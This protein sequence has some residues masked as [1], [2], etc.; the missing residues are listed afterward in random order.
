VAA[1]FCIALAPLGCGAAAHDATL[2]PQAL[3][4]PPREQTIAESTI[5]QLETCA[6]EA[7]GRF[8]KYSHAA[9]FDI[10]VTSSGHVTRVKLRTSTLEDSVLESCLMRAIGAMTVPVEALTLRSSEPYSGGEWMKRSGEPLGIA[11]ALGG[12]IALGP[13]II[14]AGGATIG[15][16]IGAVV[17]D[18]ATTATMDAL[19]EHREKLRCRKVLEKCIA[20]CS[21]ETLP[22]GELGGDSFHKCRKE[23]LDAENCWGV[24]LH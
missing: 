4:S 10:E 7:S 13:I 2:V 14:V 19:D 11:Q 21:E 3:K 12:M 17:V 15:L 6:R 16:Y 20:K 8:A 18:K 9:K 23:C 1:C 22:T 24:K 5:R